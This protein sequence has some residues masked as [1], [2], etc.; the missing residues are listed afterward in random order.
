MHRLK[1]K[2]DVMRQLDMTTFSLYAYY[3]CL[4]VCYLC[5]KR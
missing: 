5:H 4:L 1:V 2:L 3:L